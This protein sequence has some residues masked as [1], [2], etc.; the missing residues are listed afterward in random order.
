MSKDVHGFNDVLGRLF[1]WCTDIVAEM[2]DRPAIIKILTNLLESVG[3]MNACFSIGKA[4]RM[5]DEIIIEET[6]MVLVDK[7]T[8]TAYLVGPPLKIMLARFPNH[9][10]HN[11]ARVQYGGYP[12]PEDKKKKL[13]LKES[14]G[15]TEVKA[16]AVESPGWLVMYPPGSLLCDQ[17]LED[18]VK[19]LIGNGRDSSLFNEFMTI[20]EDQLKKT[21][22]VEI[23]DYVPEDA[24]LWEQW[25]GKMD[26]D[27][28]QTNMRPK[29]FSAT[30]GQSEDYYLKI[31][32]YG[33]KKVGAVWLE[34]ITHRTATAELG[35]LIGEP[36]LWGMGIGTRAMRAMI[37]IAK[38]D[39]NLKFLWVSVREA[40]QRAVNCYKRG[41]FEIVR[42]VP[43]FNKHDGSYQMWVHMEKMI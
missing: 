12:N 8:R 1:P 9:P 26:V 25:M 11:F 42:K 21:D 6:D 14:P 2:R 15:D 22:S 40:N 31:L 36:H 28:F 24:I 43:V 32:K 34:Q 16:K 39:L 23:M 3:S 20:D 10:I 29:N 30:S 7:K 5:S 41:G 33:E 37:D 38:K 17:R 35:L 18:Q 19:E 27:M 13:I 4:A